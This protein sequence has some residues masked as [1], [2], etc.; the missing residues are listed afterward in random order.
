MG[1]AILSPYNS[2][3]GG[4]TYPRDASFSS[5]LDTAERDYV[6]SLAISINSQSPTQ[7]NSTRQKHVGSNNFRARRSGELDVFGADRYFSEMIK[8]SPLPRKDGD[9][10][11]TRHK[12]HRR[13]KYKR[14]DILETKSSKS[15]FSSSSLKSPTSSLKSQ[16]S[17][18]SQIG[19]LLPKKVFVGHKLFSGFQWKGSCFDKK[20]ICTINTNQ[21]VQSPPKSYQGNRKNRLSHQE[22]FAFPV[23][24]T[25]SSL[26]HD[27]SNKP[28][29]VFGFHQLGKQEI[30]HNLDTKF[31]ILAWNAIPN[32][33]ITTPS[34]PF[35]LRKKTSPCN[36]RDDEDV[37]SDASSDLFE[38][39]NLSGVPGNYEP[40]EGSIDWSIITASAADNF[41]SLSDHQ[42]DDHK[43]TITN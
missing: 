5:Y 29:D 39:E 35:P 4:G 18:N 41:S 34:Y 28:M 7:N 43:T 19:L 33:P 11:S 24:D 21:M 40:S 10:G 20:S 15:N 31:S 13:E 23:I 17:F 2:N 1:T 37:C 27:K 6:R 22:H 42:E 26:D 38:I 36:L 14:D 8:D 3:K 16:G 25:V 9:K 32:S 30:T 12:H